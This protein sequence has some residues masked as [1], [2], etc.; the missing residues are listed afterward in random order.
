DFSEANLELKTTGVVKGVR[1]SWRAKERLVLSIIDYHS[2]DIE[3]SF[4]S[5]AYFRKNSRLLLVVYHWVRGASP[6]DWRVVV[7]GK[8]TVD[9]LPPKDRQ[10]IEDDWRKIR[11]YVRQGRAHELSE[12]S[13]MYLAACTKG[14]GG[15]LNLR[16]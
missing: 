14:A 7:V 3:Q 15:S 6:M 2:L 10:I 9:D 1:G 8:L 12:G 5:S 13:T 4:T 11:A 16:S